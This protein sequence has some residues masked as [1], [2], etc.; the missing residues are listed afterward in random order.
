[1]SNYCNS[2]GGDAVRFGVCLLTIQKSMLISSTEYTRNK[3]QVFPEVAIYQYTRRH[4]PK[5]QLYF[6][7]SFCFLCG[8]KTLSLLR[9]SKAD[10]NARHSLTSALWTLAVA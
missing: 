10:S 3:K 8:R 9:S 6:A 7:V 4:I 5:N 1:V 2:V